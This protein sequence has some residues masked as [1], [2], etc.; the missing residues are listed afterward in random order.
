MT[1]RARQRLA[2]LLGEMTSPGAFSAQRTA[3]TDDLHLEVRGLG[4]LRLPVSDTQAKR[5]CRLGRPARYGRGEATLLD[6]R[7]RDTW[8]IPKSRVK[9]DKRQWNK[10]LLP[11]LDRLRGDLGLPA[12]C[13]LKAELHSMLVYAPG[14]FF[15]PHQDSEKADA[16]VGSLVVTLPA[17]FT[18]GALV[19]EHRGEKATYRSSKKSLS[20]VAFYA[21][22][23]HEVK[24]VKSGHRIVL[25]YNLFLRGETAVGAMTE[26]PSESVDGLARCLD[27]HFTTPVASRRFDAGTATKAE[28][29][30]P[31]GVPARPRVHGTRPELVPSQGQRCAAG[32]RPPR[33]GDPRRL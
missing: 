25:T 3:P 11:V 22:C 9:V 26:A 33:G 24:P 32:G 7:V 4:R 12:G 31:A 15:V 23:R 6:S 16:M 27:E 13:E 10:T 14:Q 29:P 20:F 1:T 28:S 17:S 2:T 5:L 21:D 30:Q 18:G 19:V 8:E